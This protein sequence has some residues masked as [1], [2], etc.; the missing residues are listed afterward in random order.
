MKIQSSEKSQRLVLDHT[1][2]CTI[3]YL[4]ILRQHLFHCIPL[5]LRNACFSWYL[6]LGEALAFGLCDLCLFGNVPCIAVF[7]ISTATLLLTLAREMDGDEPTLC[8]SSWTII[9]SWT[10]HLRTHLFSPSACEPFRGNDYVLCILSLLN[11]YTQ[12]R[13]CNEHL[14]NGY[15]ILMLKKQCPVVRSQLSYF[16][17]WPAVNSV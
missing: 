2:R 6:S 12:K 4:W 17:C 15:W 14:S 5:A 16:R 10:H 9:R 13:K 8:S 3:T 7:S 11:V 1:A